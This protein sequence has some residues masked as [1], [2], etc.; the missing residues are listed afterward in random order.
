MRLP[1]LSNE[2]RRQLIDA[3][4]AFS[5]WRP[6]AREL[7]KMGT[8]RSQ[9]SKGRRYMYEVHG[10]VRKSLGPETPALLKTKAE[11]DA[12]R[13]ALKR[14]MKAIERRLD[15]MAPVNRALGLGRM[16]DI[17]ARIVRALDQTGLLGSHIIV[18]GTNALY[19]YEAATGTIL[20]AEQVATTDAD[21]LWDAEE[22][23]ELAA[24]GIGVRGS[25]A[26]CG[27]SIHPSLQ[28]M[29][30][31]PGTP[32]DTSSISF[33]RRPTICRL[34]GEVGTWP[35][36]QWREWNGYW[37]LHEFQQ[38][39]IGAGGRPLLIIVPE[40]R[41]FALH[42]LS[43][44]ETRQPPAIEAT[45][46]CLACPRRCGVGAYLPAPAILDQGYAVAATGA[47]SVDPGA[48]DQAKKR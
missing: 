34:S 45:T 41:T 36:R 16:P 42:K 25:W 33:A 32:T 9:T 28:T 43:D 14:S 7:T 23:L 13:V 19:A 31:M 4:Q 24:T 40:P 6:A 10:A 22:P 44:I 29:A 30:S 12:R 47:E 8:L 15:D 17:A 35:Q 21:L 37:P 2:Q 46:R 3:Q 1:E 5:G 48:Q 27:E 38:T 11:H 39:I 20:P 18:A 26:S